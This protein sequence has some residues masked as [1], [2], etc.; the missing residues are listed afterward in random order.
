MNI[1][2][3]VNG[4]KTAIAVIGLI[5]LAVYQLS[6]AQFEVAFG[7]L[8]LALGMAGIRHAVAKK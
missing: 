7:T 6:Q 3:L 5:G 8:M 4:L 2:N 1:L